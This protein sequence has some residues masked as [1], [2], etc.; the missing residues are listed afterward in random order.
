MNRHLPLVQRV[1]PMLP[2]GGGEETVCAHCGEVWPC[3]VTVLLAA[4][5]ALRAKLAA[6]ESPLIDT[7]AIAAIH[8]FEWTAGDWVQELEAADEAINKA[9]GR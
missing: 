2:G 3:T 1:H 7:C 5:R 6:L 9:E 8:G 4:L